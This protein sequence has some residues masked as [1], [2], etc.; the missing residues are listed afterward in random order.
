V[1]QATQ[2]CAAFSAS[3]SLRA[4]ARLS[5]NS[6]I[7]LFKNTGLIISDLNSLEILETM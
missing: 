5:I 6:L 1:G 2:A 4:E 3:R 7:L